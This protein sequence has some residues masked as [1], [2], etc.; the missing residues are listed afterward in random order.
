METIKEDYSLN[1][2][3]NL[4]IK[5]NITPNNLMNN[6]F[7][8]AMNY[9]LFQNDIK[10]QNNQMH[11]KAKSSE[12]LSNIINS[13]NNSNE[14]QII[15]PIIYYKKRNSINTMSLKNKKIKNILNNNKILYNKKIGEYNRFS[16]KIKKLTINKG[17]NKN[18]IKSK[19]M[20]K[21]CIFSNEYNQFNSKPI[22]IENKLIEN[23]RTLPNSKGVNIEEIKIKKIKKHKN[24]KTFNSFIGTN[25]EYKNNT[26]IPYNSS[27]NSIST[28]I[29]SM[30]DKNIFSPKTVFGNSFICKECLYNKEH[31]FPRNFVYVKKNNKIKNNSFYNHSKY[32]EKKIDY[33]QF[34]SYLNSIKIN[35]LDDNSFICDIDEKTNEREDLKYDSM[36]S[37]IEKYKTFEDIKR[38][39]EKMNNVYINKNI[40]KIN[41]VNNKK[42]SFKNKNSKNKKHSFN[43]DDNSL[44]TAT[45]A[46]NEKEK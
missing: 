23:Y 9:S 27:E 30:S 14:L 28:N 33:N 24:N 34:K 12:L 32:S 11:I 43:N 17:F 39:N 10:T 19:L 1:D 5:K 36:F 2:S 38:K 42:H 20:S 31:T 7:R 40:K 26:I 44:K 15:E 4:T 13:E 22:K 35:D 46:L 8:S 25:K 45:F 29:N 41:N 21:S 16:Q 37:Y 3:Y 6:S 18:Y